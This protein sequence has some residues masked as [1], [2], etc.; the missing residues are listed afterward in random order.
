MYLS[1]FCSKSD[2][3]VTDIYLDFIYTDQSISAFQILIH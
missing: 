2:A 1:S 3:K